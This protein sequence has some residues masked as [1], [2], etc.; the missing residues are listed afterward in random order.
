MTQARFLPATPPEIA[1]IQAITAWL[2]AEA[3]RRMADPSR[4]N[5]LR[6]EAHSGIDEAISLLT[7]LHWITPDPADSHL[8]HIATTRPG[9]PPNLKR[10]DLDSALHAFARMADYSDSFA[11]YR[12]AV[13][14]VSRVEANLCSALAAM[15][16]LTAAQPATTQTWLQR[17]VFGATSSPSPVWHWTAAFD[18]WVVCSEGFWNQ[19]RDG[20]WQIDIRPADPSV[21][22][23]ALA[24][25][26]PAALTQ[27][28]RK[29]HQP[30]FARWFLLN[31]T[32]T[33]WR[34]EEYWRTS[35]NEKWALHIATHPSDI[36]CA[37]WNLRLAAGLYLHLHGGRH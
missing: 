19:S 30:D 18:P 3:T 31:W 36:P 15:G 11:L 29:S 35:S 27:L 5:T 14:P 26:P 32:G 33:S 37:D 24:R 16:F 2:Y 6:D 9:L 22:K 7:A 20:Q 4:P 12:G 28:S 34:P 1:L 17:I 10:I 13:R 21:V 25:L 8:Y 23:G